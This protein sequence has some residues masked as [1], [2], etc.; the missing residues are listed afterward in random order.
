MT[1]AVLYADSMLSS[2]CRQATDT[3]GNTQGQNQ[4]EATRVGK[5]TWHG[6]QKPHPLT[7]QGLHLD[8][9][10]RTAWESEQQQ[11]QEDQEASAA[12]PELLLLPPAGQDSF[13]SGAGNVYRLSCADG[14]RTAGTM[15]LQ[16]LCTT[17]LTSLTSY[18]HAYVAVC[19]VVYLQPV[20]ILVPCLCICLANGVTQKSVS[21]ECLT[22]STS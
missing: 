2:T 13:V 21:T 18:K 7:G 20:C 1:E 15:K 16:M 4:L 22:H 17:T 10:L 12:L 5:L 8:P 19:I 3:Q 9:A 11:Q 6:A 14:L